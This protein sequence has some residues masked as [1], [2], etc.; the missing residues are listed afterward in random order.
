VTEAGHALRAPPVR[1][2]L[3]PGPV[4]TFSVVIAAYQ[5]A[6]TIAEAVES[7]L[8]Q[9]LP[10]LEVI[11]CDDGSTDD[12]DAALEPYRNEI[13]F[14]RKENRGAASAKNAAA[15]AARGEFLVILDADDAYL[16]QR[17]EALAELAVARPDLD[18]LCTDAFLEVDGQ[19]VARFGEGCPFAIDDQR[20]AILER[21]FC[22]ASACRRSTLID[23]GGFDEFLRTGED[24][25]CLIRLLVDAGASAGLVDEPLYRYRIHRHSLTADRI[26]T[27][28]D[29]VTLLER[30]GQRT[31]LS[32]GE[33]A[34]L[35]RSLA[36]QRA[37]LTLT[38]AEA[39]LRSR[40]QDARKRALAVAR[41]PT[42][43][44]RSRAAALAATLAPGAAAR[45][46]ERRD[47]RGGRSRLDRTTRRA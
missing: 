5:A 44:L 17:L 21:C 38:V 6:D 3:E 18:I 41:E 20:A 19:V 32:A 45:A 1:E 26:G 40:S 36:R 31:E 34:A 15:H 2:R 37:T 4:P 25:E 33:G 39:A 9:T 27:L 12:L 16:P 28:R 47:A 43:P 14:L 23:A 42:I 30:V 10:P 22:I 7:A 29:R 8:A 35:A 13:V 24:W 46:L 11:V